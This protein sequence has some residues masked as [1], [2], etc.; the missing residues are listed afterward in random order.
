MGS[1][2]GSV[3]HAEHLINLSGHTWG[4]WE[5]ACKPYLAGSQPGLRVYHFKYKNIRHKSGWA[6][7]QSSSSG[8][9]HELLKRV[10]L[11]S[12]VHACG[13]DAST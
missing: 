6:Y 8:A 12:W 5:Q 13:L 10:D 7:T 1:K 2:F 4:A 11:L 3:G 9:S